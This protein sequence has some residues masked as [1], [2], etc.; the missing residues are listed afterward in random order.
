MIFALCSITA[1]AGFATAFE[2][3][4]ILE[5]RILGVQ[6]MH[7]SNFRFNQDGWSR[8]N[9]I[10]MLS[11]ITVILGLE[12]FFFPRT[13]NPFVGTGSL[14]QQSTVLSAWSGILALGYGGLLAWSRALRNERK[15]F[16]L[17]KMEYERNRQLKLEAQTVE[18]SKHI[19]RA[20]AA[21]AAAVALRQHYEKAFEQLEQRKEEIEEAKEGNRDM[22]THPNTSLAENERAWSEQ[23]YQA[24]DVQAFSVAEKAINKRWKELEQWGVQIEQMR[25][26]NKEQEEKIKSFRETRE[27]RLKDQFDHF[28]GERERLVRLTQE[29]EALKLEVEEYKEET[30]LKEQARLDSLLAKEEE[31][32]QRDLDLKRRET[33]AFKHFHEPITILI[34][35]PSP[36]EDYEVQPEHHNKIDQQVG[37]EEGAEDELLASSGSSEVIDGTTDVSHEGSEDHQEAEMISI[38]SEK[39]SENPEDDNS[40]PDSAENKPGDQDE[41][42]DQHETTQVATPNGV[43]DMTESL[44]STTQH[45]ADECDQVQEEEEEEDNDIASVEEQHSLQEEAKEVTPTNP[46]DGDGLP[47]VEDLVE[48][49]KT[50]SGSSHKRKEEEAV[51]EG[52]DKEA[53]ADGDLVSRLAAKIVMKDVVGEASTSGRD[54][55][56]S[57]EDSTK[58]LSTGESDEKLGL[59]QPGDVNTDRMVKQESTE[60]VP[61]VGDVAEKFSSGAYAVESIVHSALASLSLHF[62]SPTN[63]AE[64]LHDLIS[65]KGLVIGYDPLIAIPEESTESYS[66]VRQRLME[67]FERKEAADESP[68]NGITSCA[69]VEDVGV[70]K[71]RNELD[72]ESLVCSPDEMIVQE[73]NALQLR[74]EDEDCNEDLECTTDA[75]IVTDE[76]K[77]PVPAYD[78]P[79]HAIGESV[80]DAALATPDN[81][82]DREEGADPLMN[83]E[84]NGGFSVINEKVSSGEPD[85]LPTPFSKGEGF[86]SSPPLFEDSVTSSEDSSLDEEDFEDARHEATG[87]SRRPDKSLILSFASATATDAD[88]DSDFE[89]AQDSTTA[90]SSTSPMRTITMM[91]D[92]TS[93]LVDEEMVEVMVTRVESI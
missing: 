16:H 55:I 28:E 1:A 49:L 31:L 87:H 79:T 7:N 64:S 33:D 92:Q 91:R 68:V 85:V 8:Q 21:G 69:P 77:A 26:R 42:V 15:L 30:R 78:G 52:Q 86:S 57:D 83:V 62:D 84:A 18:A 25:M 90:N 47:S 3:G 93:L 89:D 40:T 37:I 65:G 9:T 80:D 34:S 71:I 53:P 2:T 29:L 22:Y 23:L 27:N 88:D 14:F 35:P 67:E 4:R 74:L 48:I 66:S 38:P 10:M 36:M 6:T 41:T 63:M 19:K 76:D 13:M 5:R 82:S 50:G 39:E 45:K 11:I 54:S 70:G 58:D 20:A 72:Q 44:H 73:R 51:E 43:E 32:E 75:Q 61:F 59:L 81:A 46:E 17:A 12:I 56:P 60:S 24:M